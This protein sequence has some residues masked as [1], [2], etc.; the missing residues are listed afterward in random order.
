[1]LAITLTVTVCRFC[2]QLSVNSRFTQLI[3]SFKAAFNSNFFGISATTA[4]GNLIYLITHYPVAFRGS[5]SHREG[6]EYEDVRRSVMASP[7]LWVGKEAFLQAAPRNLPETKTDIAEPNNSSL[8]RTSN[9][10][11]LLD[12]PF[13]TKFPVFS[14]CL[15]LF[16]CVF[17]PQN[18]TFILLLLLTEIT[19]N[20]II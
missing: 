7:M 5:R 2:C 14:L 19:T 12:T 20:I 13:K 10:L 6:M 9:A 18:I 1:M 15:Q 17:W 11:K 16:P 8:S 4:S 3:Q